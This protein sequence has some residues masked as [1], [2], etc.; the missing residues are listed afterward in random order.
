MRRPGIRAGSLRGKKRKEKRKKREAAAGSELID[1]PQL[2]GKAAQLC[3]R[4][5]LLPPQ[6]ESQTFPSREEE[7]E[8]GRVCAPADSTPCFSKRRHREA[9][10]SPKDLPGDSSSPADSGSSQAGE[11]GPLERKGR[12]SS[13][14]P[15][16]SA[17][18]AAEPVPQQLPTSLGGEGNPGQKRRR[19]HDNKG[20]D[21][22]SLPPAS[23]T[24]D[25]RL[26]LFLPM[27]FRPSSSLPE[28][29]QLRF[30]SF[31]AAGTGEP[32]PAS[33]RTCRLKAAEPRHPPP[34]REGSFRLTSQVR[35]SG[36][37]GP[38][39]K[40]LG[41]RVCIY[42]DGEPGT[43]GRAS[44]NPLSPYNS[45]RAAFSNQRAASTGPSPPLRLTPPFLLHARKF[46]TH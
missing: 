36:P 20:L 33:P 25:G 6:P 18:A 27:P 19:R 38:L 35:W 17:A 9:D 41:E 21:T 28:S 24:P 1:G 2:P 43:C 12:L 29:S 8:A 42:K 11:A 16:S 7:E 13:R 23:A 32:P 22:L 45:A 34:P 10:R 14:A 30:C 39:L 46:W 5:E 37:F 4:Q 40:E 3:R 44:A 15:R 31:T 26:S